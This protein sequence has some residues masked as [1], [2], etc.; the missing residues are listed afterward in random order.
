MELKDILLDYYNNKLTLSDVIN[1]ISIYSIEYVENN[2]AQIDIN[3]NLRKSVPEV[4]LAIK[5][6]PKEIVSISSRILEKKG[7]VLLSKIDPSLVDRLSSYFRKKGLFV[8]IGYKSTSLL[9]YD[10]A[11]S[12]P[13]NKGG[14]IGIIC[15]G[16][17]DIGIAEEVRLASLAMGC[18]YKLGYDIGIAGIQ[19]LLLSL[20]G[21]LSSNIDVFVVVAGMEAA[22]PSV[23][24]SLVNVPVIGV[25]SSVGYGFG[26][27]GIGALTSMLQSCSFGLSVVN[28]DNGIGAGILAGLI[29]N[30]GK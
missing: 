20:K 18:S 6:K 15:G 19:R 2:I 22:L 11:N 9:I 8:E 26:G 16:T 28:I 21:M 30:K 24:T 4:V 1:F 7:Y 17:S 3:R 14:N 23:V 25:P 5:K 29:A 12:L 13:R 27:D 10:N